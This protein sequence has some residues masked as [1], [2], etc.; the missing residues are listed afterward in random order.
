[1]AYTKIA[2]PNMNGFLEREQD[3]YILLE[4][5]GKIIINSGFSKIAKSTGSY[6]KV[7]KPSIP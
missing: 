3:D 2:K 4:T 1:M 7:A 6:S 5:G